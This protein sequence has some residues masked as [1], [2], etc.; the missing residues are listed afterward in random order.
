MWAIAQFSLLKM[1]ESAFYM[2]MIV[3]AVICLFTN[4][5]DPVTEQ[6][7]RGSLFSYA[8]S[9]SSGAPSIAMGS[10]VAL[11][12]SI[13]ISSFYGSSEIPSDI[14]SGVILIILS[15]PVGRLRY[16]AG[17]YTAIVIMAYAIFIFN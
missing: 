2:L 10:C 17:K 8:F 1:R 7:A 14:S 3:A 11:I 15:K 4:S 5:A 13:L 16:L 6:V 9:G 12:I